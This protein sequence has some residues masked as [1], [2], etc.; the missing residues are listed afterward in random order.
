MSTQ[1]TGPYVMTYDEVAVA[2]ELRRIGARFDPDVLAAT[3]ALYRAPA[4]ALPWA[5]RPFVQDLAYGPAERQR[6]DI[7]PTDWV[8]APIVIFLHGGGFVGGDK[9]GDAVFYGNVGRYFAA[10]GFLAILPNYRLAPTAVWPSGIEDVSAA[11]DWIG[12][13]AADYGGDSTRMVLIGQSAGAAHVA[14]YLFD[15]RARAGSAGVIRAAALMSGYYRAK[16][17]LAGG[18][19]LYFGDDQTAW[20]SRSPAAHVDATH[21]PL[22]LSLAELDPAPIA[23]QTLDLA[24]AL[25]LVDGSPPR[26]LWF[27]GHN[28]VSTVHGL[29][30]GK[31]IVGT[32]LRDFSERFTR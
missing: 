17:P 30:L 19:R 9:R 11:L 5:G 31:D 16:A 32:A 23:D 4:E 13:Y 10:H 24:M 2:T 7:Y 6:L 1:E 14:G 15:Q 29:G 22:M 21:P 28:H 27:E 3:R 18:P 20:P 26:L 25:N 8:G 12:R